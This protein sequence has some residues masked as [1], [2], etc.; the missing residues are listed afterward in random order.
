MN[1]SVEP[2]LSDSQAVI[3]PRLV[4]QINGV[5]QPSVTAFSYIAAA[6]IRSCDAIPESILELRVFNCTEKNGAGDEARTRNFQLGMLNLRSLFSTLTKSLTKKC[7]CTR[8]IPC[9]HFLICVSLDEVCGTVCH[10]KFIPA[11]DQPRL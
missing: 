10:N 5:A 3:R 9:T 1:L 7:M 11:G 8:R 4:A 2:H 6:T